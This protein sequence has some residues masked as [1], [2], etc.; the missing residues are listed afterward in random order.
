MSRRIPCSAVHEQ[1]VAFGQSMSIW[2]PQA[3][4]ILRRAPFMDRAKGPLMREQPLGL[5]TK[6]VANPT[7]F[8]VNFIGL[9]VGLF[10]CLFVAL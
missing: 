5:V 6:E 1:R 10:V 4:K 9:F 3:F 2:P 7:I 8:N